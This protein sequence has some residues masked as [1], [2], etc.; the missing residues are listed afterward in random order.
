MRNKIISR[1]LLTAILLMLL[2]CTQVEWKEIKTIKPGYQAISDSSMVS[3]VL[4]KD[5]DTGVVTYDPVDIRLRFAFDSQITE[6]KE[7]GVT[8]IIQDQNYTILSKTNQIAVRTMTDTLKIDIFNADSLFSG[9]NF[10]RDSIRSGYSFLFKTYMILPSGDTVVSSRGDYQVTPQYLNF[11]T[12]PDIPDGVWEAFNKETG[13]KK[14][15]EIKY[16]EIFPSVW[17]YVITDFGI[18]WSRWNDFWYGTDFTLGCP[19]AG[20]TRFVVKL[21]AWGIDLPTIRLEMKNDKGIPETRPLR[22]MP[23]NYAADS[24]DVG[25]Y[26]SENQQFI[27]KNVKLVDT[28]WN[29]DNKAISEI[30]FTFKG[31]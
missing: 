1:S 11:C 7:I 18:D 13:F 31:K 14:E 30:T 23:W 25:Y 24:P 15:V 22:I 10:N 21:A 28:W 9:L 3:L 5:I 27:F 19:L 29:T 17:F 26:D 16:M 2:A 20:D 8:K 4:T 6:F 12:L